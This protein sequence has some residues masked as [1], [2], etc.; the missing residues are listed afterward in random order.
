MFSV[1]LLCP[2]SLFLGGCC[3]FGPQRNPKPTLNP[4][5]NGLSRVF[6]AFSGFSAQTHPKPQ[7]V[8]ALAVAV[9][10]VF[11]VVGV[12]VVVAVFVVM[13][14][15]VAVVIIFVVV[16]VLFYLSHPLLLKLFGVRPSHDMFKP[17]SVK[18][19]LGLVADTLGQKNV[20]KN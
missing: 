6:V 4:A 16:V 12:V 14:V 8:V 1:C 9:V 3:V 18:K 5:F 2:F 17:H 10:V 13:V 7:V 19:I 11:V 15:V 20:T